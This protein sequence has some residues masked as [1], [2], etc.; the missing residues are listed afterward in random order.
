[1]G[2][3]SLAMSGPAQAVPVPTADRRA[4]GGVRRI[5]LAVW[6]VLPTQVVLLAIV[7]FPTLMNLWLSLTSWMPT[8]GVEWWQ[9]K[10]YGLGNFRELLEDARFIGAIVRTTAIVA[11]SLSAE[12]VFGMALAL[13]FFDEFPLKKLAVSAVIL[14]MMIV[15]VD[16]ANA[17]FMLFRDTGPINQMLGWLLRHEFR[18]A[19]LADRNLAIVPIVLVEIWQWTPLMFM[20]ML[21]GLAGLP[22]NQLKAA[23]VLGASPWRIFR[24]LIIPLM[25]PIILVSLVIRSIEIFK[26]FDPVFILTRGGPGEATETISMFMYSEGFVYFRIAYIAAAAFVVLFVVIALSRA[27]LRPL[28][29]HGT[30]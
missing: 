19:W 6:L 18:F 11:V 14:P 16:A 8:S 25:L 20:M 9:A 5:P 4:G 28:R 30:V 15:P 13:L 21:T 29:R 2:G 22:P 12:C 1:M 7:V 27:I 3:R 17:F 26:I 10:W 24:R 23:A